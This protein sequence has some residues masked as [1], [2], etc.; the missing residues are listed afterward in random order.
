MRFGLAE[1]AII[2]RTILARHRL[3]LIPGYEMDVRHM[4]TIS[5][6]GGLPVTVRRAASASPVLEPALDVAA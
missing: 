1:V 3:E 6:R 5:P 4:P 2:A